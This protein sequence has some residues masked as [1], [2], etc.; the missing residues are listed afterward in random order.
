MTHDHVQ[1]ELVEPAARGALD[2]GGHRRMVLFAA[3]LGGFVLLLF[4]VFLYTFLNSRN[5]INGL[6][7]DVRL[8]VAAASDNAN[9]AQVL[10]QQVRELGG[11]PRVTAPPPGPAGQPGLTGATGPAGPAGP[12]GQSPPCLSQP[13]QCRGADG[14]DGVNGQAG[15]D[16]RDGTNG[17]DGTNG[18]NG[19]NGVDGQS[20]PCLSE[21]S[22]CR[23]TDGRPPQGWV[24]IRSDGTRETCVRDQDS[25]DNAPT[26]TCTDQPA[27]T[28]PP[29]TTT[30]TEPPTTTLTPPTTSSAQGLLPSLTLSNLALPNL[31]PPGLTLPLL[32]TGGQR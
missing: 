6:R 4:A 16:G 25:P 8:L 23:G 24:V 18:T 28:P 19:T 14:R 21:P 29:T 15:A 2:Q 31:A 17:V 1:R 13:S 26:Y 20:P 27:D 32:F 3:L 7:G 5:E 10:E 9:R 22:Q 30:T 11:I 12:A